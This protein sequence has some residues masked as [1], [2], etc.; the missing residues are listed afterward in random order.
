MEKQEQ[1]QF[2]FYEER[3]YLKVR[4]KRKWLKY[5]KVKFLEEFGV[6]YSEIY[7]KSY[8]P[9]IRNYLNT[10]RLTFNSCNN[11]QEN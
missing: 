1:R 4:A 8:P 3:D 5:I 11:V 2:F 6:P 9:N 7:E 10:E